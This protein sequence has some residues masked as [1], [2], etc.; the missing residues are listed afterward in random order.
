MKFSLA[1]HPSSQSTYSS[2]FSAKYDI[3]DIGLTHQTFTNRH[4][5]AVTPS[6]AE[7]QAKLPPSGMRANNYCNV[8]SRCTDAVLDTIVEGYSCR[9]RIQ[10]LQS[11]MQMSYIDSC[12]QVARQEY[13]VECGLCD[14]SGI[15]TS[16]PSFHPSNI[17]SQPPS[18]MPSAQLSISPTLSEVASYQPSLSPSKEPSS[19]PTLKLSAQP[20]LV[21]SSSDA[22]FG[23]PTTSPV[24]NKS[25][26]SGYIAGLTMGGLFFTG[27]VIL[28]FYRSPTRRR[29]RGNTR[30]SGAVNHYSSDD[31]QDAISSLDDRS[32]L[33]WLGQWGYPPSRSSSLRQ[34]SSHSLPPSV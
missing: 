22:P 29:R 9:D 32:Y 20:S 11:V 23:I 12:V 30:I 4:I 34:F 27:L 6:L 10:W 5:P 26:P 3:Q 8:P 2:H 24:I 14:P 21:T 16:Q 31:P 25:F 18:M 1:G 28:I 19:F 13:P 33:S 17:P 7:G 15:I